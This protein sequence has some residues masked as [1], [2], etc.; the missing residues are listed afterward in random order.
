M[1]VFDPRNAVL[2]IRYPGSG[3]G[4]F[5]IPDLGSRIPNP[6]FYGLNDILW[7]KSSIILCKLAKKFFFTSSKIK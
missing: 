2:W 5:R 4:F 3:M 7:E 6:Y 1:A